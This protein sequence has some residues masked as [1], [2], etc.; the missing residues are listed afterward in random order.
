MS[1][2][3]EMKV[4]GKKRNECDSTGWRK[5]RESKKSKTEWVRKIKREAN[6]RSEGNGN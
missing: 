6:K 1:E 2:K 4:I 3:K 5:K